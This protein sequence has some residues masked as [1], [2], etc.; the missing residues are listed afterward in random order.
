MQFR[1]KVMVFPV[2]VYLLAVTGM[3][4]AQ[5]QMA[6]RTGLAAGRVTV[7]EYALVAV[8]LSEVTAIVIVLLPE[9][10]GMG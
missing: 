8:P 7:K 2:A 1:E 5:F 4:V 3:S 9:T 10:R 6:A